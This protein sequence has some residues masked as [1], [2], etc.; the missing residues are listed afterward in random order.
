M[1]LT[2]QA[3]SRAIYRPRFATCKS[4]LT[5]FCSPILTQSTKQTLRA[6]EAHVLNLPTLPISCRHGQHEHYMF[7]CLILTKTVSYSFTPVDRIQVVSN[8]VCS[9]TSVISFKAMKAAEGYT[10]HP[11]CKYP[12]RREV[13]D[14]RILPSSHH[15][16]ASVAPS[17]AG[18]TGLQTTEVLDG[19]VG[20]ETAEFHDDRKPELLGAQKHGAD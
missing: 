16:E 11:S 18:R 6:L 20:L 5:T 17:F 4:L 13:R 2:K 10:V 8:G 19:N 3:N 7:A 1:S 15:M 14:T 9:V 12:W